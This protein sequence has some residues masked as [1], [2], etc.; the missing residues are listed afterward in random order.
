MKKEDC[1]LF[2]KI[3]K[4][5]GFKGELIISVG[6]P[7]ADISEKT[8]Y[9]FLEIEGLLVPFFFETVAGSGNSLNVKFEDVNTEEKSRSLC[10]CS[11]WVPKELMPKKLKTHIEISGFTGFKISDKQKGEIGELKDILE[12]PQQQMLQITKGNKEIL[13]PVNEEIILKIDKK[14][15]IIFIDAP[16]GLIDIYLGE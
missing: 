15:K 8:S 6:F 3:I 14:K 12:M 11:I 10:G 4:T 5:H 7:I 1:F 13:I 9:V 16:E 2:G